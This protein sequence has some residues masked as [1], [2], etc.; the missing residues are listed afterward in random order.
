M[1]KKSIPPNDKTHLYFCAQSALESITMNNL[2]LITLAA[3]LDSYLDSASVPGDQNGIYRPSKR[4]VRRIGL[5]L[6]PWTGID[7]WVRQ[8]NLDA[9]FLHRP[10]HLDMQTLPAD[11]GVLAYH[12]AFDLTL[13]LGFNS[14]LANILQMT[15]LVPFAYKD[16]RPLGMLGTLPP[17]PVSTFV[18]VLAEIFGTRPVV[19]PSTS[20]SVSRIAIVGAMTDKLIRDAAAQDVHLYITGQFRQPARDA[21]NET[22]M[23][24]AII[25]HKTSELWGLRTLASLLRERWATLDVVVA[26]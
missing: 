9:L 20:E 14:R 1:C 22:G 5:A 23:A 24:V 11:V 21:V 25:G 4:A 18:E 6:E 13:T 17:V 15:H 12:L 16:N 10:W 26:S 7:R 3:Y 2:S 19:E 8:E